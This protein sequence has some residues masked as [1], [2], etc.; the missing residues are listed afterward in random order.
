MSH[1]P[2]KPTAVL[3]TFCIPLLAIALAAAVNLLW[4]VNARVPSGSMEP[5]IPSGSFLL[6]FRTAYRTEEP[7]CGD[8]VFF[9]KK[10]ISR[11]LLIK[12]I[13][14]TPGQTVEVREGRVYVDGQLLEEA[15]VDTFSEDTCPPLTVP[16]D[17]YFM[18]GD[19]RTNSSDSRVWDDPFVRR[20]DIVAEA[21]YLLFPTCKKIT[22]E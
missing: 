2:A 1:R 22:Q 3:R 6:G 15:Y 16:E 5:T 17:C 14:A 19:N 8:I 20:E 9:H 12:R 7:Q 10:D 21:R 18:L 4:I 11:H 13:I